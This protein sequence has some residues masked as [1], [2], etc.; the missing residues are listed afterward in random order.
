M[1]WA[2]HGASSLLDHKRAAKTEG[3]E[4]YVADMKRVFETIKTV[5]AQPKILSTHSMGSLIALHYLA[6]HP[7]DFDQAIL[8]N[9]LM[10][11][12][13]GGV[14][15]AFGRAVLKGLVKAGLADKK[16]PK[17]R[18]IFLKR[19]IGAEFKLAAGKADAQKRNKIYERYKG[20]FYQDKISVGLLYRQMTAL[21][22]L[23]TDKIFAE[24]KVPVMVALGEEDRFV[25]NAAAMRAKAQ[26]QKASYVVV[27]KAGHRLWAESGAAEH[28]FKAALQEFLRAGFLAPEG[29]AVDKITKREMK[30]PR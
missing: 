24:I 9:P 10:D 15:R 6:A 12:R 1:E 23:W 28:L 30:K 26:F 13:L 16:M 5:E 14:R 7:K 4:I 20:Q 3:C 19:L 18:G 22:R 17:A 8:V 25:S 27:P 29:Q 21:E 11:V 2:G